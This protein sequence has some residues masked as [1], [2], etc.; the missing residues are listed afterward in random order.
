[1]APVSRE[2]KV[3]L[4][5]VVRNHL[6]ATNGALYVDAQVEI[7]LAVQ[8]SATGTPVEIQGNR[9]CLPPEI[10]ARLGLGKGSLLAMIQREKAVA[11]KRMQIEQREGD[12]AWV[13]DI[14]TALDVTRVVHTNA[15]PSQL[16]KRLREQ[17]ENVSLR[18]DVLGFLRGRQ[19]LE[20]WKARLLLDRAEPSDDALQKTLIAERV[21][22]QGQDGSW[23]NRVTI[24]AR[25]LRELADLGVTRQN[26][27]VKRAVDWLM[28]RPQSV[29]NPGM[30][31]S[32]DQLIE[33]QAR[34]VEERRQGTRSR[35]RQIR[36]SEQQ[37]VMAGDDIIRAPCGPRIMWPNGLVLEALLRLDYEDNDR[38]QKALSTM[39]TADWCECGYQHGLSDW[40]RAEPLE[41]E[42]IERFEEGCAGEFRYGG[43]PDVKVLEKAGTELPFRVLRMAHI[44]RGDVD[45]YPLSMPIHIQGC[46]A[47]T[48][49]AMSRVRN[50]KVRRFAEAHLY[51]FASQQHAQDGEFERER[52]GSGV[53]QAGLLQVFASY[54]HPVSKVVVM[55]SIPWIIDAQNEDGSWGEGSDKDASTLA[56]LSALVSVREHLPSG[57][58]P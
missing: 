26:D 7:L 18:R 16:L 48:T 30:F 39:T 9:L 57:V 19:T 34:V 49:R 14:E 11:L 42:E 50:E 38:V 54:D 1:M 46:E 43:W 51:R 58:I 36:K 23:E 29:H 44:P 24:T 40:R 20:A 10:V 25:N 47:I 15:V 37:L 35:F 52:Y 3:S 45:E 6:G 8:R 33:E 13:V 4:K 32:T 12:R 28:S 55:R 22:K 21:A 5:K 53:G 27:H 17:C 31:F 41:M 2:G 56:V